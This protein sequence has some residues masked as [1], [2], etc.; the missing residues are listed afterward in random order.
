[1]P[2]ISQET[3][4]RLNAFIDTL[5]VEQRNKCA[6]C[7]ETL[8]HLVKTAEVQTGAGTATVTR[9]L[10]DRINEDAA[11][12]DRVK[13]ENLRA[14]VR[15]AEGT[16]KRSNVP[17]NPQP[18]EPP[19]PE[20]FIATNHQEILDAAKS[21]KKEVAENHR[22]KGTGE[23]EWYTPGEYISK[24]RAVMGSITLDPA[25]S[26]LSN[27]KIN[28]ENIFT[29]FE[30]GLDQEWHGNVWLNPPYSQPAINDFANKMVEE[31]E[32]GRVDAAIVL[33][34][35]YT[36]TKWFHTLA[37]S[38]FAICFTRGRIAF[39]NMI[40]EKAAPTQGQAFFYFGENIDKFLQEFKDIGFLVRVI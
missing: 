38:C 6:L 2:R 3:I 31:W 23:N 13:G 17:N 19:E 9:A 37:E 27:S 35:N 10:A 11:P 40:G 15:D 28:A 4:A 34:H 36:D 22:A 32:S 8:T 29:V 16:L 18:Q 14:R 24:A 1:M 21:I 12:G 5:P 26:E 7:N 30:N 25:T 39:V 20:L 33:T